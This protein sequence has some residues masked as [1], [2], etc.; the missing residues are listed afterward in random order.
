MLTH[1]PYLL[2]T[3][4]SSHLP[5]VSLCPLP[6]LVGSMW[7]G[8]HIM[9]LLGFGGLMQFLSKYGY[10]AIGYTFFLTCLAL[11][12]GILLVNL[13]HG[14]MNGNIIPAQLDME[15][16]FQVGSCDED[17]E[18][19]WWWLNCSSPPFDAMTFLLSM[20][21]L[22]SSPFLSPNRNL[23]DLP[24][25]SVHRVIFVL[26]PS[27]SHL[28][29]CWARPRPLSCYGCV[30]SRQSSMPSPRPLVPKC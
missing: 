7:I 23:H 24:P 12:W 13:F 16:L 3:C 10:S 19:L 2:T 22:L 4:L 5:F 30:S 20:K 15:W 17:E 6:F 21:S 28:V 8:V 14:V 11:Q 1:L 18:P 26:V 29:L 27:S 25:Q 9:M